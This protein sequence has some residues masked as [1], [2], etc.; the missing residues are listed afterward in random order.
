MKLVSF[1]YLGCAPKKLIR[2]N[3]ELGGAG[4]CQPPLDSAFVFVFANTGGAPKRHEHNAKSLQTLHSR[5]SLC[6][7]AILGV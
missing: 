7:A 1:S 4:D 2:A 3:I 5:H 6:K